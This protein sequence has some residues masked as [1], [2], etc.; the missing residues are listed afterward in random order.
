V[1][2][3]GDVVT[4]APQGGYGKPRPAVVLQTDLMADFGSVIACP[5]T[6]DLMEA[7]F[8]VP[9]A[10]TPENGLEGPAS[11]MVDKITA[12]RRQRV[13]NTLAAVGRNTMREVE[14]AL[15]FTAGMS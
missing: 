14:S 9:V 4:V 15:L 6:S 13:G 7:V 1:T 11:I 5:I 12:V 2:R 3:L 8:R 10:P